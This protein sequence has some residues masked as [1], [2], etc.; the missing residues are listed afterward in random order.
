MTTPAS[1]KYRP[2]WI[3]ALG[4][5]AL[6]FV[7]QGLGLSLIFSVGGIV[8]LAHGAFYALGAYASIEITRYLGFGPEIGRAS[9]RERVCT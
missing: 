7:L 1:D 3:A 5:L 2:L 9:C 6:P 4:L 8:N